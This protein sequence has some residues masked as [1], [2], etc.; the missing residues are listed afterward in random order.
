MDIPDHCITRE[1]TDVGIVGHQISGA[2]YE[3][4]QNNQGD[5]DPQNPK[6]T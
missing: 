6:G 4:A 2:L 1:N 3:V 5:N